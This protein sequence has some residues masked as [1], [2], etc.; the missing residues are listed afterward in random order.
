MDY[1]KTALLLKALADPNRLKIVDILSCG[2]QCACD[3]LEYFEFSQPALSHHMKVLENAGVLEVEKKGTW[4]HYHLKEDFQK[5]FQ[6]V[7]IDLFS[8]EKSNCVCSQSQN[9][10]CE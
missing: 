7:L 2:S 10:C 8:T 5:D 4:N 1:E 9:D 3:I 6:N